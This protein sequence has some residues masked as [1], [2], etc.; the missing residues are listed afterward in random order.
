MNADKYHH[1]KIHPSSYYGY[2]PQ[3]PFTSISID[4][5]IQLKM[6]WHF[7]ST[8]VYRQYCKHPEQSQEAD[9]S[10][11]NDAISNFTFVIHILVDKLYSQL[12]L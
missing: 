12:L 1:Y 3:N 6:R 10:I 9:I 7:I 11:L 5:A 8:P 2:Y 4:G